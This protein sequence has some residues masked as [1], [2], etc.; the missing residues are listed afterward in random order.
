MIA[1]EEE[2]RQPGEEKHAGPARA[3][4]DDGRRQH[5]AEQVR[6]GYRSPLGCGMSPLIRKAIEFDLCDVA[7]GARIVPEVV[8]PDHRPY[9]AD[10]AEHPKGSSPGECDDKGGDERRGNGVTQARAGM[11]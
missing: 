7:V 5:A 3:E 8:E 10:A 4:I 6:P 9:S 2:G 11:R 1:I